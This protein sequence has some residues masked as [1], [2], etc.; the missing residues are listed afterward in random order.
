MAVNAGLKETQKTFSIKEKIN[1]DKVYVYIFN[2]ESYK[3]G[4]DGYIIPNYEIDGSINDSMTITIPKN[5]AVV[6]SNVRL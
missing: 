2:E 3:L 1:G 4:A 6:M 5:T